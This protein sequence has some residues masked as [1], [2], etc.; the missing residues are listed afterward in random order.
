MKQKTGRRLITYCAHDAKTS[1]KNIS[2]D[3]MKERDPVVGLNDSR[4][5]IP[6]RGCN[7][8]LRSNVF[9][10][11]V[12]V[13]F[14]WRL[15]AR[16]TPSA[17]LFLVTIPKRTRLYLFLTSSVRSLGIIRR[18]TRVRSLTVVSSSPLSISVTFNNRRIRTIRVDR[19]FN[20]RSTRKSKCPVIAE[21]VRTK[22]AEA[23]R[24]WSHDGVVRRNPN[25]AGKRAEF[26][27]T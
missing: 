26:E 20:F 24:V 6:A 14:V 5:F 12:V 8:I 15:H 27:N 3:V 16:E 19:L 11:D 25:R 13:L 22:N 21:T 23:V 18:K 4:E 1:R 10:C 7:P 2:C 9:F 17:S